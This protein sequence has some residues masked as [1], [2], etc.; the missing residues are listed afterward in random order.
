MR[1]SCMIRETSRRVAMALVFVLWGCAAFGLQTDEAGSA[2]DQLDPFVSKAFALDLAPGMAIAV[3][4]DGEVVYAK[5]FGYADVEAGR[6]VTPETLFY[7]ASTT[8]SFTVPETRICPGDAWSSIR[9]AMCTARPPISEPRRSHSPVWT[10]VLI[11][12]SSL[13]TS[14]RIFSAH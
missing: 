6:A 5:G 14:A 1:N 7:I 8:K 10:P 13:L 12:K 4:K 11:S 3:V 2:F 9:A